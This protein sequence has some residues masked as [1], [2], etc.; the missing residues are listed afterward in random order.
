MEEQ[1]N[2]LDNGTVSQPTV[3]QG[4]SAVMQQNSPQQTSTVMQG[5][6]SMQ[7]QS[8]IQSNQQS[9]I[10]TAQSAVQQIQATFQ[11]PQ[12]IQLQSVQPVDGTEVD[13]PGVVDEDSM[14]KK[15]RDILSRRPSYRS[16]VY[17]NICNTLTAVIP[18]Y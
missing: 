13:G 10:Q 6:Q 18:D 3:Q 15:R 16:V 17:N 12:Q 9:V 4:Q 1:A 8:V 5:N 2:D 14:S 11:H 7:A